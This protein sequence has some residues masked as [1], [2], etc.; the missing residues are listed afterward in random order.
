M[1]NATSEMWNTDVRKPWVLT[2]PVG[3][4]VSARLALT[5]IFIHSLQTAYPRHIFQTHGKLGSYPYT[6]LE[7][8]LVHQEVKAATISKQSAPKGGKAVSPTHRPPLL[9]RRTPKSGDISLSTPSGLWETADV[10]TNYKDS[11]LEWGSPCSRSRRPRGGV[12]V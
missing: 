12:E 3:Q 5:A 9:P 1:R 2:V 10:A 11:L 8:S 7:R 4:S 6:G